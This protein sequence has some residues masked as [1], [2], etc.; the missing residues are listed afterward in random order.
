MASY[1][2]LRTNRLIV[3]TA[4]ACV[5]AWS[6]FGRPVMG[7]DAAGDEAPVR[8]S[9]TLNVG[10][11]GPVRYLG[12]R[13]DG[14][15]LIVGRG[16]RRTVCVTMVYDLGERK[17]L[18]RFEHPDRE[19]DMTGTLV[20]GGDS[21]VMI[22]F[23]GFARAWD[24]QD[25]RSSQ[26][27]YIGQVG[28][29]FSAAGR[30]LATSRDG[31]IDIFD[32][33][34]LC[35][36]KTLE[37]T[38]GRRPLGFDRGGDVL[39]VVAD[40]TLEWWDVKSGTRSATRR[41]DP[42]VRGLVMH[43]PRRLAAL[44]RETRGG[45]DRGA[46][47]VLDLES[48][49]FLATRAVAPGHW[50]RGFSPG[51]QVLVMNTDEGLGLWRWSDSSDIVPIRIPDETYV[52]SVIF[53][54]DGRFLVAGVEDGTVLVWDLAEALGQKYVDT[55]I[56]AAG[57]GLK[58]RWA[59]ELPLTPLASDAAHQARK[60][61]VPTRD[62][63][64]LE[65]RPAKEQLVCFRSWHKQA[66]L[67]GVA[68]G[69]VLSVF[70]HEEGLLSGDLS[71]DGRFY[72]TCDVGGTIYVR[73][74]D[75]PLQV[76]RIEKEETGSAKSALFLPG[77]NRFVAYGGSAGVQVWDAEAVRRV[78]A[79]AHDRDVISVAFNS[80]TGRALTVDADGVVR[81]WDYENGE[82]LWRAEDPQADSL[83]Y[84][85]CAMTADGALGAT[86]AD[87]HT[88]RIWSMA[89]GK[90]LRRLHTLGGFG[91]AF[92]SDTRLM[93]TGAGMGLGD[94]C[95]LWNLALDAVQWHPVAKSTVKALAVS[96]DGSQY[97]LAEDCWDDEQR[98][99]LKVRDTSTASV[100]YR[101]EL[102]S[103]AVWQCAF[104]P[105]GAWIATCSGDNELGLWAAPGDAAAGGR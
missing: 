29:A 6:A 22:D 72:V 11:A 7:Q 25:L 82:L 105:D 40:G 18:S 88:V 17:V 76:A 8:P 56:P 90:P 14:A 95:V 47:E 2:G 96:P 86:T 33:R 58:R 5:A 1:L 34:S 36:L 24:A 20:H 32:L 37:V 83:S 45:A 48:G 75:R 26:V 97:V 92:L 57:V 31:A 19:Q 62:N 104:S 3:C 23:G 79:L 94:Q 66:F 77:T 69:N 101:M 74:L 42:P 9:A 60:H 70:S 85:A 51:G 13:E 53:S 16:E 65:F 35:L 78:G 93:V 30:Y 61:L 100:L 27:R 91:L 21:V 50:A 43:A 49:D 84:G 63:G 41:F 12:T 44:A 102:D 39:L 103:D 15:L 55:A 28:G 52:S 80:A 64:G 46:V 71:D 68:D 73:E 89:D 38:G 67:V 54:R 4:L 59:V 10:S 81:C 99:F 87:L 98:A